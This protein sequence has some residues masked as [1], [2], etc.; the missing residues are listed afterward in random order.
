MRATGRHWH[1]IGIQVGEV[2][3]QCNTKQKYKVYEHPDGYQFIY[4]K[5]DNRPVKLFQLQ[6]TLFEKESTMI[7]WK[8]P[9]QLEGLGM[10]PLPC[11]FVT[12]SLKG[13]KN[14]VET[15]DGTIYAVYKNTGCVQGQLGHIRVTNAKEP[16]EVAF[17][18]YKQKQ[19]DYKDPTEESIFEAGYQ[20][21]I[22]YA[23]GAR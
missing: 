11:K 17:A 3:V 18:D 9:L 5:M 15:A 6:H 7:D 14:I 16:W 22:D 8:K 4:S 19:K 2:L 21:G 23:L 10:A 13:D 20:A 1:D 12:V